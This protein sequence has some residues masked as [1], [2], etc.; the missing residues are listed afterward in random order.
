MTN[1]NTPR[2]IL[3]ILIFFL[4]LALFFISQA[5]KT[6]NNKMLEHCGGL[7]LENTIQAN[8]V[9]EGLGELAPLA[10]KW[11]CPD[12][13]CEKYVITHMMK[14]DKQELLE[15]IAPKIDALNSWLGEFQQDMMI[16]NREVKSF[17]AL[18]SVYNIVKNSEIKK[19]AKPQEAR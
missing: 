3:L 2:A 15:K 18:L 14:A 7:M 17:N 11:G 10:E 8:L 16:A 6:Q 1:F 4:S 9:P 12:P 5:E 13:A 19:N